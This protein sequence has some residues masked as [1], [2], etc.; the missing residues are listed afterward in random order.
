MNDQSDWFSEDDE[1]FKKTN[2]K[3]MTEEEWEEHDENVAAK[4]ANYYLG[5]LMMEE[6]ALRDTCLEIT[7]N[8]YDQASR[9]KCKEC[10]AAEPKHYYKCKYALKCEDCG[11]RIDIGTPKHRQYCHEYPRPKT[12]KEFT[13]APHQFP[14]LSKD[15][16]APTKRKKEKK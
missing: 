10:H 12:S 6:G 14:P 4:A 13:F 1:Y 11:V 8:I 5:A 15:L 9:T 3:D 16:F 2:Y 7:L